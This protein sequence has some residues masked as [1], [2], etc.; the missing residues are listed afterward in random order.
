MADHIKLD[1]PDTRVVVRQPSVIVDRSKLPIQSVAEFALTSSYAQFALTSSYAQ[2]AKTVDA[3]AIG[4]V[5][6]ISASGNISAS[7]LYIQNL[8]SLQGNLVVSGSLTANEII[9]NSFSGSFTGIISSASYASVAL[10]VLQTTFTGS[11]SGSYYGDGSNL[12]FST[13][14]TN[15]GSNSILVIGNVY[16]NYE[17]T[18]T[19]IFK[20]SNVVVSG[21]ITISP[22]GMLVLTPRSPLLS[23]I[24]GGIVFSASGDFYVGM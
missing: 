18:Q 1:I 2:F 6:D 10:T 22:E 11:F 7:G 20:N 13:I 21:S 17:Y 8:L 9:A 14:N 12:V 3:G 24:F 16:N 19:T 23:P 5:G 4:L 15:T